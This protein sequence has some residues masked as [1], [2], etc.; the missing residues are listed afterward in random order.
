MEE[1]HIQHKPK[2][3][4]NNPRL[5]IGAGVVIVL[6]VVGGWFVLNSG[7]NSLGGALSGITGNENGAENG[8]A[9]AALEAAIERLTALQIRME[10]EEL[11]SSMIEEVRDI[12]TD[13]EEAYANETGQAN[14]LWRE[15]D[16]GLE[17]LEQDL[18]SQL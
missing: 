5:Y 6:L 14:E 8:N 16:Q 1:E 9:G 3:I 18:Q 2:N 12:R 7:D 17:E 15:L 4:K 11:S 13:L 10:T